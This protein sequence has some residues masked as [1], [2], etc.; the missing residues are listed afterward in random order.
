MFLPACNVI[1]GFEE[2]EDTIRVLYDDLAD[3]L[4]LYLECTYI[5]R[6]RRNAPRRPPRFTTNLWNMFNR[7]DDE[8]QRTNNS[9]EG[10]HQSFQ[11]HVSVCH[12]VL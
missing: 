3:D 9:V 10:W 12:P 4:L 7:N 2:L 5:D 11:G 6:Y 8:L 1:E